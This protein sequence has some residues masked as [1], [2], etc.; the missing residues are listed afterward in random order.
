VI[1]ATQVPVATVG[2]A[3][4]IDGA[5]GIPPETIPPV[6][7]QVPDATGVPGT[8]HAPVQTLMPVM[9]N[10]PIAT[11]HL[12]THYL[13][14]ATGNPDATVF[15]R[16]TVAKET[17]IPATVGGKTGDAEAS[18]DSEPMGL[19]IAAVI[20]MIVL[21]VG[22]VYLFY[23]EKEKKDEEDKVEQQGEEKGVKVESGATGVPE[24]GE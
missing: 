14:E 17:E 1:A 2:V 21:C 3:S 8:T 23:L 18:S 19:L 24:N 20:L 7:T 13:P 10:I 16:T 15:P 6:M 22:S 4:E 5:T 12:Q 11:K 9:T